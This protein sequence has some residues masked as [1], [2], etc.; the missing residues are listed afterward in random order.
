MKHRNLNLS[1]KVLL[2]AIFTLSS[3]PLPARAQS[4]KEKIAF[5]PADES[6]FRKLKAET[7]KDASQVYQDL[8][9]SY[10]KQEMFDRAMFYF[11]KAIVTN[12]GLYWSWYY[13]GLMHLE[14][15]E[16]YFKKA[17]EANRKFAP[18]YYWLARYYCKSKNIK[19]SLRYFGEYM[20]MAQR[21][22]EEA[23]R[24]EIAKKFLT[25]MNAGETD[26]DK[27]MAAVRS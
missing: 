9:F 26:F 16:P 10:F 21:D 4:E 27:I 17:I 18:A 25:Q 23:G 2:A 6:L 5:D 20:K 3:F 11:R 1:L 24:I 8:G 19:E 12:P 14:S 13:M 15:A 22:P 7:K